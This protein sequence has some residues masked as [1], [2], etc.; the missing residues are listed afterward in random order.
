MDGD[1][2]LWVEAGYSAMLVIGAIWVAAALSTHHA[3]H[4]RQLERYEQHFRNELEET[5]RHRLAQRFE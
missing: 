4:R 5:Y 1:L 2:L 3:R